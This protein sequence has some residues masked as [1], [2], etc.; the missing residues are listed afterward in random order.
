VRRCS[1]RQKMTTAC[2]ALIAGASSR[3]SQR[4]GTSPSVRTFERNHRRSSA[5]CRSRGLAHARRRR[6]RPRHPLPRAPRPPPLHPRTRQRSRSSTLVRSSRRR[7][8]QRRRLRP[9]LWP[10]R[11]ASR[12]S[13]SVRSQRPVRQPA[14]HR[15]PIHQRWKR[16]Q[17]VWRSAWLVVCRPLSA[18][19]VESHP[20][21]RST[22]VS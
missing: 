14:R 22:S 11:E 16:A 3:R 15:A 6:Q 20:Y 5:R 13:R 1:R 10:R 18:W 12:R 9:R 8:R 4:R 2:R 19:W 17:R 7:R 21:H